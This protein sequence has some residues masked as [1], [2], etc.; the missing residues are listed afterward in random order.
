MDSD[1]PTAPSKGDALSPLRSLLPYTA[2]PPL[3]SQSSSPVS[4]TS[5]SSPTPLYPPSPPSPPSAP[6]SPSPS[7]PSSSHDA[8]RAITPD[9][10]RSVKHWPWRPN[11]YARLKVEG[12]ILPVKLAEVTSTPPP[13][14]PTDFGGDGRNESRFWAC[15]Y[16][17][18][19]DY[20]WWAFTVAII[21]LDE[22]LRLPVHEDVLAPAAVEIKSLVD[23]LRVLRDAIV[24]DENYGGSRLW[25]PLASAT[26]LDEAVSIPHVCWPEEDTAS[27]LVLHYSRNPGFFD[28]GVYALILH[29]S[30]LCYALQESSGLYFGDLSQESLSRVGAWLRLDMPSFDTKPEDLNFVGS[31]LQRLMTEQGVNLYRSPTL[32][33]ALSSVSAPHIIGKGAYGQVFKVSHPYWGD[34]AVKEPLPGQVKEQVQSSL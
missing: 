17:D 3:S 23:D 14:L 11:V 25:L 19:L 22:M 33:H 18:E 10:S 28:N 29:A 4:P 6:S 32:D 20:C 30:N 21:L 34:L 12:Q 27:R 8:S 31:I 2:P 15:V 9:P 16:I 7:G 5:S 26:T 1:S 13:D 24:S